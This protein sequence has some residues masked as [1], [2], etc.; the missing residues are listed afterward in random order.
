MT[1]ATVPMC[2]TCG[3]PT[4]GRDGRKKYCDPCRAFRISAKNAMRRRG[5]TLNG[6]PRDWRTADNQLTDLDRLMISDG[7]GGDCYTCKYLRL[8]RNNVRDAGFKLPC[9]EER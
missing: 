9:F 2:H 8:C 3:N 7:L 1:V 4:G 6:I 5:K